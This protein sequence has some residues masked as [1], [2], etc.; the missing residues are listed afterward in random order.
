MGSKFG[1]IPIDDAPTESRFGGIPVEDAPTKGESFGSRVGSDIQKRADMVSELQRQYQR[2]NQSAASTGLQMAGAGAGAINDVMGEAISSAT[3]E[4]VKSGI[5]AGGQAIADT[6]IV[7]GLMDKLG[8]HIEEAVNGWEFLKKEHPELAANIGAAANIA[9]VAPLAKAGRA[10]EALADVSKSTLGQAASAV[11]DAAAAQTIKQH[12][13]FVKNLVMPPADETALRRMSK[14]GILGGKE[15]A[16]DVWQQKT[17]EAVKDLPGISKDAS[18]V[19]NWQAIDK[20]IAN[21]AESLKAELRKNPREIPKE[22]I[23]DALEKARTRI[24]ETPLLATNTTVANTAENLINN[25]KRIITKNPLTSEG[26]LT[27]RQQFDAYLK[28]VRPKV[29]DQNFENAASAA[30]KEVRDTLNNIVVENNP[31]AGVRDSLAKQSSLFEARDV[32][33]PKALQEPASKAAELFQ[34]VNKL[35]PAD[36]QMSPAIAKAVGLTLIGGATALSPA[37]VL[38]G[39]AALGTYAGGKFLFSPTAKR[40]LATLLK[41]TDEAIQAAAKRNILAPDTK[42]PKV[43]ASNTRIAT[44]GEGVTASPVG[45]EG[46]ALPPPG[47]EKIPYQRTDMV[48]V[49]Q[50]TVSRIPGIEIPSVTPDSVEGLIQLRQGL[51]DSLGESAKD[52]EYV[53]SKITKDIVDMKLRRLAEKYPRKK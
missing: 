10:G 28:T 49:A 29:F 33:G 43:G 52:L 20:G 13:A 5:K 27:A 11:E 24:M 16:P 12:D 4:I 50:P 9:Q 1:G 6:G 38:A 39:G 23:F 26:L 35:L 53:P 47:M 18:L 19:E 14:P 51:L 41:K 21:E 22:D 25:A 2:G 7:R 46:V 31:S 30:S 48:D 45:A 15:V 3:P 40:G 44:E 37:T 17:I 42:T 34:S 36:K 32:V 8:P